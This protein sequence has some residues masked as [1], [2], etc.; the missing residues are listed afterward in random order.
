MVS[1]KRLGLLLVICLGFLAPALALADCYVKPGTV[2]TKQ[3]WTQYKDC[4]SNGEQRLWQG[5]MFWKM[6]EDAEIHVWAPHRPFFPRTAL[7]TQ[8][9]QSWTLPTFRPPKIGRVI[10][11]SRPSIPR[12]LAPGITSGSC[13]RRR[14]SPSTPPCSRFS[15][16]T[17]LGTKTTMSS[18]RPCAARCAYLHPPAARRFSAA[19][20]SKTISD[21]DGTAAWVSL[22]ANGSAT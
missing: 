8:R 5:D 12:R 21:T 2:I 20:I 6:P 9:R 3:N 7:A 19:T 11:V 10:R 14:S 15:G 16:R 18:C 4:F 22:W 13:S 1:L 17:I